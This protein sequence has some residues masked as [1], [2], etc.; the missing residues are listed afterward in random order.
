MRIAKYLYIFVTTLWLV[1]A[2]AAS[3]DEA[4]NGRH[5]LQNLGEE[6]SLQ[7]PVETVKDARLVLFNFEAAQKLGL[8]LPRDPQELEKL[9]LEKFAIFVAQD[10][11]KIEQNGPRT[12]MATYYMDSG[13][14]G[15]GEALGDGR[16]LWSGEIKRTLP[17]GSH[18]YLD[19]VLKGIGQTPLAWTNHNEATHKDGLQAMGEGVHSFIISQANFDNKMDSTVDLAVIEIPLL[20]QNKYTGQMEKA[21]ITLRVGNQTRIAHF[22]FF[23]DNKE[24]FKKMADYVVNREL[25]RSVNSEVT[26][27]EVNQYLKKFAENIAVEGAKYIDLD[28]VHGS[29]TMGNRTTNG[30]TIDMGT[31]RYL[32]A[33]HGEYKYLFQRYSF[34]QQN[35]F[36]KSYIS[37]ITGYMSQNQY[38]S[39]QIVANDELSKIYDT[40]M[41]TELTKLWLE[42][43]GLS[44]EQI[45]KVPETIKQ[46]FFD[47]IW[48]LKHIK[49]K[50]QVTLSS[51]QITPAAFDVREIFPQLASLSVKEH[52][53]SKD[54]GV[55]L[56]NRP[57]ATLEIADIQ[58]VSSKKGF[59]RNLISGLLQTEN[60]SK[61]ADVVQQTINSTKAVLSFLAIPSESD[62][63]RAIEERAQNIIKGKQREVPQSD[64][65]FRGEGEILRAIQDDSGKAYDFTE[66]SR[67]ALNM[68]KT[69]VD[70][71]SSR[72]VK[73]QTYLSFETKNKTSGSLGS[74]QKCNKVFM[75]VAI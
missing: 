32:D 15:P 19:F 48:A 12:M 2:S 16:A 71:S 63:I 61:Y 33:H 1:A 41:R 31:F 13:K 42:R 67:K 66:E 40:A 43:L 27:L 47:K 46:D 53:T 56:T 69:L 30:S 45:A 75:D 59:I 49:G 35:T 65:F 23:A 38:F 54:L 62:E 14:K 5:S 64:S 57:W 29:P 22:A 6:F 26:A 24:Q 55:F 21:A 70:N 44:A 34:D 3:L 10:P 60:N 58:P 74:A 39:G 52:L 4:S 50:K 20:K 36:M 18:S 25:G 72:S 9:I 17:D 73:S 37:Y 7:I 28:A 8:D 51:Q 68:T 11:T